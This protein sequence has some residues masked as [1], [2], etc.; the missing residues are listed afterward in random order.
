M[1]NDRTTAIDVS[2][3][4]IHPVQELSDSEI[5]FVHA[6][7]LAH[8]SQGQLEIIDIKDRG[9]LHHSVSVRAVLERWGLLPPNSDRSDVQKLGFKVTKIIREGEAK[10]VIVRRMAMHAH[11][12]L[13][14][15]THGRRGLGHLFGQ[16]LA[17]YLADS[18]R[19]T[20]LYV[21]EN[22]RPFVDPQT[23]VVSLKKILIP[24]AE[25]PAP[26]PSFLFCKKLLALFPD[27]SPPPKVIGLHC[28]GSFPDLDDALLAGLSFEAHTSQESVV[29]AIVD[30]ARAHDVDLVIMATEG[31]STLP[32]KILGSNTEQVLHASHC[33]VL[34][35]SV[36]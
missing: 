21:P 26:G 28:G 13:V 36:P 35:I 19:Q 5:P 6:L 31:R 15:G 33:P 8:A 30:A 3:N 22:A 25:T 12:M 24:V 2:L 11:D 17:E 4:I 20:T 27:Q 23:G 10:K 9:E 14:I 32:K 29:P 34:S 18:F 16:E 7:K 1:T